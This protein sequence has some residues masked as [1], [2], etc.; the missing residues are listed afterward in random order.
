MNAYFTLINNIY[1]INV[2]VI[3]IVKLF[4]KPIMINFRQQNSIVTYAMY[5]IHHN[6]FEFD[7]LCQTN[8]IVELLFIL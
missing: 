1:L 7:G 2:N 4:I 6:F 5:Y 8:V 3:A